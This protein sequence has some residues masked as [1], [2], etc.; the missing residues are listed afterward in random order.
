MT[1]E[2]E[3]GGLPI[4]HFADAATLASWLKAQPAEHKG[5]WLKIA[6]KARGVTSVSVP[7]AIDA[8][9]CFGWID[10]LV[11]R[12]DQDYYSSAT[13]RAGPDRNGR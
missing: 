8:G 13:R 1:E 2:T 3:R 10:G 9:L 7:E 6:K 4:L 5:V 12:F 11:N